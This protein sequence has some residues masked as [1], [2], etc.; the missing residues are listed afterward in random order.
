[1]KW[2]INWRESRWEIPA[3]K[4]KMDRDHIVPLSRQSIA[5]LERVEPTGASCI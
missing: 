3:A 4:M 5:V 1:M 2:E